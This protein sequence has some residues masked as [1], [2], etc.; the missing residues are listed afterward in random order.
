[1]RIIWAL[2]RLGGIAS[3]QFDINTNGSQFVS[4]ILGFLWMTSDELVF[5]STIMTTKGQRFIEI[6]RDGTKER[7]V[8]D[9]VMKRTRCV[10]GRAT[11]SWKA[12]R[13]G[14]PD[15]LFVKDSWQYPER[16][17][18]ALL[19]EATD[20]GVVR[21]ARY[22]HHETVR[23]R[24]AEDDIQ[25]NVRK[26]LDITHA[27]N[28]QEDRLRL[29]STS[30]TSPSRASHGRSIAGTKRSSDQLS[31]PLPDSKRQ[32]SASPNNKS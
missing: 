30:T 15:V 27:T 14:D 29:P 17:E 26:G 23:V 11:T 7:L 4:T 13:D 24:N 32:C 20:K 8:F 31:A 18:G 10:A 5:D 22:Y 2:D 3:E 21:I 25:G 19:R 28:H 16:D 6:E 12:H 1:M 9:R